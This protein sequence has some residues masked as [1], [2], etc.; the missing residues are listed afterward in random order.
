MFGEDGLLKVEA[1]PVSPLVTRPL[2]LAYEENKQVVYKQVP[3]I[4]IFLFSCEA[5]LIFLLIYL[6]CN[7]YLK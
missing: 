3:H 2:I 6:A 1:D 4:K 5:L 7:S